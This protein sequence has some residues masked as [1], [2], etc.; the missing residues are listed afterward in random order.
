[1]LQEQVTGRSKP[2]QE[3]EKKNT[4]HFT[5]L[6]A[7]HILSWE[8]SAKREMGEAWE[9]ADFHGVNLEMWG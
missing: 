1:M 9:L 7:V 4:C 3:N 2:G 8:G 5:T 6:T